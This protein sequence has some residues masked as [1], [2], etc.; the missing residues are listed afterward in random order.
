MGNLR[1]SSASMHMTLFSIIQGAVL[2]YL[3]VVVADNFRD[4]DLARWL[5]VVVGFLM[6]VATW[7]ENV[8]TIHLIGGVFRYRDSLIAFA[9]GVAEFMQMR[10]IAP[11]LAISYWYFFAMLYLLIGVALYWNQY[12]SIE[13]KGPHQLV[14]DA[15]KVQIRRKAIFVFF[16]ALSA[17]FLDC[18]YCLSMIHD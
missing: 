9:L 17:L 14:L 18:S 5:M 11:D 10:A 13:T 8:M 16:G 2:S 1:R 4:F 15:I 7:Q 6:V 3:V 12:S